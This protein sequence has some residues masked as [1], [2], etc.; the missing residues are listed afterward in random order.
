MRIISIAVWIL[1]SIAGLAGAAEPQQSIRD[2]IAEALDYQ[3]EHYPAS[4]YRDVYKN[5]MQDF[6]GPGHILCD[7]L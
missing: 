3:L 6:F 2:S 5:F 4:H 7:F 1:I